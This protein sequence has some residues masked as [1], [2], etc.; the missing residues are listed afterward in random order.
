MP[1]TL[2]LAA[3]KQ[4]QI[5]A[6]PDISVPCDRP[7]ICPLSRVRAGSIV[8]I[9]RLPADPELQGRLR[10]LGFCEDQQIKL[11]AAESNYICLVCNARLG[12]SRKLAEAIFVQQPSALMELV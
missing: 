4:E 1:Y 5:C 12:I 9:K 11:V 3:V 10:E 8:S 6:T 2:V 7:D